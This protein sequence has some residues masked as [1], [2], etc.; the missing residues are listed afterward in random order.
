M[1]TGEVSSEV[2]VVSELGIW[3]KYTGGFIGVF[4]EDER[5]EDRLRRR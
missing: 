5:T 4:T 2:G 3:H 1:E